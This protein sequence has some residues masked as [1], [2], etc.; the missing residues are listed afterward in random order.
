MVVIT[1][2]GFI[3]FYLQL[4][5]AL[6]CE[7]FYNGHDNKTMTQIKR[8]VVYI[9]VRENRRNNQEWTPEARTM[10]DIQDTGRRQTKYNTTQ[11]TKKIGNRDSNNRDSGNRD[12]NKNWRWTE[13]LAN[14]KQSPVSYKTPPCY[15]YI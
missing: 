4:A 7:Y 11:K 5:E 15:L 14:G 12:S 9:N 8:V 1:L 6:D 10:L 3:T 2:L 13:V